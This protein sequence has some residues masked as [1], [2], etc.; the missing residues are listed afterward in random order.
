M[1]PGGPPPGQPRGARGPPPPGV[2]PRVLRPAPPPPPP[3]PP[4]LAP[5]SDAALAPPPP[6]DLGVPPPPAPRRWAEQNGLTEVA[7]PPADAQ[8]I[9]TFARAVQPL[10]GV[11]LCHCGAGVSRA[12]A[13]ALVCLA[14]WRGP[15]SEPACVPD[16]LTL[17]PSAV[18]HPGLVRF[19]DD[20]L[21]RNGT[22]TTALAA[23]RRT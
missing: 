3:P 5:T 17:R 10:P 13:A 2:A 6:A 23:A 18:P 16:L 7:P 11:L 8:A 21:Q 12:P 20:L 1:T 15:G 14:T 9:I 4:R 22:L 19:A